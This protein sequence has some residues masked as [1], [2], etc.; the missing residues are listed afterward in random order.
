MTVR[1]VFLLMI[2]PLFLVLAGVNG[3]LVYV[4]EQAEA[5]RGLQAQALAA[6]VTVAAFA[7]GQRDFGASLK[8]SGR[9]ANLRLAAAHVTG[10]VGLELVDAEGRSV[11]VAGE[12][13][14]I[15][16][17]RRP[18]RPAALPITADAGGR[19]VATALA[20]ASDGR[21]VVA[22]ID[23]EPLFARQAELRR[24]L[25]GLA[26]GATVLGFVLA[27]L[28]ARV[29]AREVGRAHALVAAEGPGTADGPAFRVRE[30]RDLAAAV[31]LMR[32]SVAAR[33]S[34]GRHE[35]ARRDRARDEA[36]A[37]SAWREGALP[38]LS[39]TVAGVEVA[40]RRL[41]EAPA[42]SFWALCAGEGRA[43]L[44]LGECE[45]PTPTAALA[46]AMAAR[47]FCERRLL[48]GPTEDRLDEA[49]RAFAIR[50]LTWVDWSERRGP[51]ADVLSLMDGDAGDKAAAYRRRA[52]GLSPDAVID[53]LAVLLDANGMVAVLRPATSQA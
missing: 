50:R 22:R 13:G 53:D 52:A 28:V 23:A 36:V 45:G 19:R 1:R 9:A 30:T 5:R 47:R 6:A 38:P 8:A 40:A 29:I 14:A 18:D 12:G 26:A 2:V 32:A 15:D 27:W 11:L 20:P 25:I 21:F 39:T 34:R 7:D 41:G 3:A 48:D 31:R 46:R 16:G 44:V 42:G 24:L 51:E 49:A 33:I 43:A 35:L 4:W 17:L 10:L 37:A